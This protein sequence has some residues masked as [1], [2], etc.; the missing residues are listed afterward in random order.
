MK[1]KVTLKN[2]LTLPEGF[3][4]VAPN[5]VYI[6]RGNTR[7]F[8]FRYM[9]NGKRYDKSIGPVSKVDL[10]QA[11]N[12]A[13]EF[14]GKLAAGES[15]LKTKKENLED[16]YLKDDKPPFRRFADQTLEKIKEVK[17]WRNEKTYSNMVKYFDTYVYPV[18]GNKRIDEIKRT[19]VLAVLQPIWITKNET[20]QKIRTRL[21]NILAYAVNDGYLE[22]NCALWKGNL[23]QYLPPPSKVRTVRHYTSMPFEELQEKIGLFLPTNNRTRQIIVFTIL[24][25][26]RV[27][28]TS[29]AK[30]S[31]FDFEN[32]IWSIPPE[33]RKDGK[34]YPHR[35]PLS[36]QALEVLKSIERT[37]EFVFAINGE[38][39]SKYS[40]TT[41]FK[42]MTGTNATMH[43]FRSTFRDWAAENA[44]ND[45]VAEKCLMHS[46]GNA[47]VQAYQRSD[48][49]ELRRPVMQ[50]WADAVLA[51]QPHGQL[52][53]PV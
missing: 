49:L 47:V 3:Y 32:N 4:T 44:I 42:R 21:E 12:T 26:C 31:E 24:T 17:R 20:A 8:V 46:V 19:D 10:T 53:E 45:S 25:A 52:S 1:T 22:F 5:L 27:G 50:A 36:R 13:K 29:G 39:G 33:R 43:G 11:K 6:V 15:L 51:L 23:D 48:L 40:L 9:L 28:E 34:P 16:E 41:M 14:L 18:I 37:S 7:R 38:E 30:W 35:V 2:Y